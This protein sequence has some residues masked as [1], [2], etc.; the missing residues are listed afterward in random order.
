MAR[1]CTTNARR[2]GPAE[3]T[4]PLGGRQAAG[5]AAHRL[6][7]CLLP[8]Q[9]QT[10]HCGG[11]QR[12][13]EKLATARV[14][15]VV[16]K[17]IGKGVIKTVEFAVEGFADGRQEMA[18]ELP[19]LDGEYEIAM[20]VEGTNCPQGETVKTFERTVFPWENLA[21]GRSTKVYPPFTPIQVDGKTLQTVLREHTLNDVGLLDQVTGQ[22]ANTG[23][24]KPLLAAPMRYLV[25]AGGADLPVKADRWKVTSAQPHEVRTEGQ[26]SAGPFKAS[27]Q[28]TWDYDGT[29]RVDLTLQPTDGL[30]IDELTLEIPFL[31]DAAT[32][33]HANADRIVRGGAEDSRG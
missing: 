9:E 3:G 8:F 25:K 6:S 18:V 14:N 20:K 4:K 12:L 17:A 15:A 32:M 28:D 30:A 31:A 11:H 22:S 29:L 23:V 2:N 7:L 13:A 26:L 21:A 19:G 27:F 5:C 10:A 33:I 1:P 24:V 16:R